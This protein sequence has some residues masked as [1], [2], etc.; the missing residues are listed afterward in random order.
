M[1]SM[2]ADKESKARKKLNK[3]FNFLRKITMKNIDKEIRSQN[4]K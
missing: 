1:Y 3:R 2:S 4:I